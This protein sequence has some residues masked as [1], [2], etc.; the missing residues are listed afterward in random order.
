M[1]IWEHS[2]IGSMVRSISSMYIKNKMGDDTVPCGT[3]HALQ[4]GLLNEFPH[5]TQKVHPDRNPE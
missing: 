1:Q 2:A 3:P 4:T 5:Q